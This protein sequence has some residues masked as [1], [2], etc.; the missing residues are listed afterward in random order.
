MIDNVPKAEEHLAALRRICL[1]PCE[2]TGHLEQKIAEHRK[3][4]NR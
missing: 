4:A 2:E 3:R 1:I